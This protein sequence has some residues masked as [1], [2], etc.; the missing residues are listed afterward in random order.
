[1]NKIFFMG[2]SILLLQ[3][4]I[5]LPEKQLVEKREHS[6]NNN[7]KFIRD[8]ISGAEQVDFD[9]SK[10]LNIDLPHDY[11]M[12]D[13]PGEDADDQIGAF[14]KKS[15]GNGNS[16]GH[17]IGGTGWYRKT[18]VIDK[19]G[20]G[21]TAILN[22]DGVYMESEVWVNGKKAGIHKNGYT[23][24][25]FDI[26]TFLN[27]P[28]K[29][30]VIAVKV[31]N[32]GRNSRWYSGSGI[33]RNVHLVLKQPVHVAEWGV[34]ITTS[35]I[36]N[37][38]AIASVEVYVQNAMEKV[39]EADITINIKDKDGELINRITENVNIK[40]QNQNGIKQQIQVQNPILWS[41]ESPNLY[42][43][44][45]IIEMN[46]KIIDRY[47][48]PFGI[49][50]IE[51]SAEKGFLLNGKQVLL[52]G[53]CVH[54]DNGLLGAAAFDRA[55]ERKVEILKANGFN[56]IRFSHN[57]PSEKFLNACDELGM[58]VVNEFTDMWEA[59]K[60]PL[61][62]SQFF[63]EWWN[64]DLT[65]M[66]LRDRNHPSIIMWS[67]GNEINDNEESNRLRIGKQLAERVR[68]LDSTRAVTQAITPF[69]YPEGWETTA[70]AFEILDVCG[71]NYSVEKFET[72]H[73]LYPQRIMYSSESYPKDAYDYWQKVEKFP[74]VIGDFVWT[75]MDY[76][77]EVAIGGTSYVPSSELGK[78][79][80][81]NFEGVKLPKGIN[82]FDIQSK[83][84]SLWP[85][86]LAECGDI[87]ITGE[88]RVQMLYRDILWDN[89]KLEIC[90]HE[91]I[92][93]G[94]AEHLGG[95]GWPKEYQSWNWEGNEGQPLQVRVF[96]KAPHVKLELNGE[97]VGEK[98]LSTEDK[99][100]AVFEVPYQPG[101]LKAIA[102]ENKVEFVSKV[103]KTAGDITSIK[104][105]ADRKEIRADRNDLAFVKIEV[106]DKNG[107]LVPKG[108][109]QLKLSVSGNGELV[110][111]GNANPK[112]MK[113]VNRE[114]I[115]TFNGMAQAII[116]PYEEK[117]SIILKVEAEGLNP[118][119]IK[120][121]CR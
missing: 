99:F 91:P 44:E 33:Y 100:I 27:E 4:C 83:G 62:Y 17:V 73:E 75:A 8:S 9:D 56:T 102:Y 41:V 12:M 39:A 64:H 40:G 105:T 85:N 92:P 5:P 88:K 52:K 13:L 57:P 19:A 30:N 51:F 11:S 71:Y 107:Q 49:R 101:E 58:L 77:G 79:F 68:M 86:Y 104:L 10:W 15:P 21:K 81:G 54:H 95:W 98:N 121:E 46:D 66:V 34:N 93:E 2:I 18:F 70:P 60:N 38:S 53:A 59:Y 43:A 84:P 28:G 111:S 67:I 72:D 119:E 106:I 117:G 24:F 16:T 35:E 69:F 55:E 42:N 26:T 116:R 23:P 61:D 80:S 76:I 97:I 14:S 114:V 113:S 96:T 29:T 6:F 115:K 89:S 50:S 22:F 74:Y 1:M 45:I 36:N 32:N 3:C 82:I 78:L 94:F 103:L 65:N 31:E 87:D 108:S 20:K 47:N 110:A 48:Q 120:I 37:N 109:I 25:W 112:D 7:W 118:N 63:N 90:V